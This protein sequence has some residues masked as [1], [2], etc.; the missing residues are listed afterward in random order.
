VANLTFYLKVS[1]VYSPFTDTLKVKMDGTTL[2][3]YTEP[4]TEETGYTQKTVD[5]RAYSDGA[6]HTLTF[7]FTGPNAGK[8]SS[9]NVDDIR[10][11]VICHHSLEPIMGDVAGRPFGDTM[12]LSNDIAVERQ[13]LLGLAKPREGEFARADAAP[14][15]SQ[16]DGTLTA[17]DII[18]V[19][20][21]VS[22]VDAPEPAPSE[23][24][25]SM[26]RAIQTDAFAKPV[27]SKRTIR[28]EQ[29]ANS[30]SGK[31]QMNIVLDPRA[32]AFAAGFTLAFD[33]NVL[34]DPVIDLGPDVS[35]DATVTT[36]AERSGDGK[37]AVLIDSGT[38]LNGRVITLTFDVV[39][40]QSL[41]QTNV[42]FTD[43]ITT[44]GISDGEGNL[45]PFRFVDGEVKLPRERKGGVEM[46]SGFREA[47]RF[48]VNTSS[49][50]FYMSGIT[51][52]ARP[53]TI[54]LSIFNTGPSKFIS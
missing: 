4:A 6:D 35:P 44:R 8:A 48:R 29:A 41:R 24:Q 23:D 19:R 3:T 15:A 11:D 40:A 12:L 32:D 37:I 43:D 53:D 42:N 26:E 51:D 10:L 36:N 39:G 9:F 2:Q 33:P 21:Y 31:V 5:M 45:I 22:G 54:G 13:F 27:E 46:T 52:I 30:V 14:R 47:N 49:R 38:V 18:Q 25:V 28:L 1:R 7:E 20:R 16:G 50:P 34:A 17:A